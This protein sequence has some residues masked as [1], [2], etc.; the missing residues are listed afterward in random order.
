[1]DSLNISEI[2]VENENSSSTRRVAGFAP[3]SASASHNRQAGYQ[4]PNS[5]SIVHA[6]PRLKRG[7]SLT[8]VEADNSSN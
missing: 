5:E 1:M 7:G 3:S 8:D 4:L 2:P 6:N